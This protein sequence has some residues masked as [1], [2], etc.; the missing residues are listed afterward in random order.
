L[1]HRDDFNHRRRSAIDDT[2]KF[3]GAQFTSVK[4]Q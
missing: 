3:S 2:L 4:S 1:E